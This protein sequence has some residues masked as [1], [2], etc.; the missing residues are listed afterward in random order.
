MRCAYCTI[1]LHGKWTRHIDVAFRNS[2]NYE[3]NK[4]FI[5]M[6]ASRLK[7]G[8]PLMQI[9]F[10]LELFTMAKDA[11]FTTSWDS[12]NP[13]KPNANPECFQAEENSVLV[14]ILV[15]VIIKQL[16]LRSIRT[17]KTAK[18]SILSVCGISG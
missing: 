13:Y 1:R 8:E 9:D 11:A 15:Y 18:R 7:R 3:R 6:A 2:E 5:R 14:T 4:P 10:L 17:C 16:T 12:L